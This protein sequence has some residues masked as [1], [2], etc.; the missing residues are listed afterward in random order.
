M[1]RKFYRSLLT[2]CLL[3]LCTA[4]HAEGISVTTV[5]GH[6]A[7][8]RWVKHLSKTFIPSVNESLKNTDQSIMWTELYGGTLAPVGG[9]L[10]A[11]E[12]GL[13]ELGVVPTVFEPSKM[14]AQ[15]ITY[16]TPFVSSDVAQIAR[17]LD[18]LQEQSATMRSNWESNNLEYLGGAIG[19]DDYLLM[20]SFPVNSLSDLQGRKIAAPGPAVNWLKG[21]GAVGVAGN[22]TTYYN[23]IKTGVYDGVIT[24]ASAA[25]PG[26][27]HEV[28]PYILRIGLGAQYGGGLAANKNWFDSQTLVVQDA[29]KLAATASREAYQRDL[30]EAVDI[31]LKTMKANGA[32]VTQASTD[33]KMQWALAMGNVAQEWAQTLDQK[34]QA[35]SEILTTY[36]NAMRSSGASPLRNWD[37]E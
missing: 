28:A 29:L 27:L 35:G 13:A 19:I 4:P 16:Y 21:T 18:D 34:G 12:E 20:S 8:F 37:Q 6:P 26:K 3:F 32:T 14:S 17:L 33:F 24:F 30:N 2:G 31:A 36:M 5:S 22:L 23:E 10:E 7:V 25:L 15:N 9:E 11:I 1:I